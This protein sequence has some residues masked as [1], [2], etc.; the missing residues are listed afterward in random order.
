MIYRFMHNMY[1]ANT[2]VFTEEVMTL[3]SGTSSP[4]VWFCID[5]AAVDDVDFTAAAA[6]RNLHA[7][8]SDQGIQLV[9]SQ[10]AD[11]VKA[12][13]DRSH[14]TGLIGA[15]AF[16]PALDAGLSAYKTRQSK[17]GAPGPAWLRLRHP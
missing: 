9:F 1:Y 5:A 14:L 8:L 6:L 7:S 4:L 16:F 17:S 11:D 12:E 13:C 10:L 15:D 3:A 2:H